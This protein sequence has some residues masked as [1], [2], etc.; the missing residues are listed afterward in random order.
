MI[1][2]F[3]Q[4]PR[5]FTLGRGGFFKRTGYAPSRLAVTRTNSGGSAINFSEIIGNGAAVGTSGLYY[6]GQC[7]TWTKTSQRWGEQLALDAVV[8]VVKEFWPDIRHSVLHQK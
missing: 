2:Q 5:Y 1:E 6:L 7:R 8:N 4:D 3:K